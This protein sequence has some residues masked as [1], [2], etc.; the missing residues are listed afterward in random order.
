MFI[1]QLLFVLVGG[2][3]VAPAAQ[4]A[5]PA[6]IDVT[7]RLY[8]TAQVPSA[9]THAALVIATRTLVASGVDVIWRSCDAADSCALVPAPGE[10]IVR[11]V[12]SRDET[13][14]VAPFVL[15]EAAIDTGAGAGVLAT[16][17]ADRVERMA[18]LSQTDAVLLLGR[19]MAHELGHLLMATN[20]HSASGLMRARWTPSDLRRNQ[21]ADWM[22][23]R[24]D[25]N[26]IRRR[27]QGT[28]AAISAPPPFPLPWPR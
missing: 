14:G 4:S 8:N 28:T 1:R 15:G 26:S 11:L 20:A 24:E 25:V 17:Y 10:L 9:T 22:L 7:A 2:L 6:R 18:G 19:T 21:A 13:Q 12:P 23:T 3:L 5:S 16:I 27:L